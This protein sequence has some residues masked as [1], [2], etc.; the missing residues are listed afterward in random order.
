M[1]FAAF[2]QLHFALQSLTTL[3]EKPSEFRV[4]VY[5]DAWDACEDLYQ[6]QPNDGDGSPRTNRWKPRE[7]PRCVNVG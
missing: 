1:L 2:K 5:N 7:A 3:A 6:H 4:Y